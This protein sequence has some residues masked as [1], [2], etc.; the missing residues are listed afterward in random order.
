MY[1]LHNQVT[2]FKCIETGSTACNLGLAIIIITLLILL[3]GLP[4]YQVPAW[5]DS[6]TLGL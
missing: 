5:P 3:V 4:K 6:A 1:V 2:A